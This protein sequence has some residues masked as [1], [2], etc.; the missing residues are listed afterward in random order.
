MNTAHTDPRPTR[1]AAKRARELGARLV[2]LRPWSDRNLA[3]ALELVAALGRTEFH[4]ALPYLL[5]LS[6]AGTWNVGLVRR[7]ATRARHA[8][9]EEHRVDDTGRIQRTLSPPHDGLGGG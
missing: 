9:L 4:S 1:P 6:L 5:P 8:L 2:A 7:A 3:D